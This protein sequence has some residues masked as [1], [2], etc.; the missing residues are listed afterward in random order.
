MSP[1]ET[2]LRPRKHDCVSTGHEMTGCS[3]LGNMTEHAGHDITA[4]SALGNIIQGAGH[5]TTWCSALGIM[6]ERAEFCF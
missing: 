3:A 1:G 6:T 5:D 4:C 2:A